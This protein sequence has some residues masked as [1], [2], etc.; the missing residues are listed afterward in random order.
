MGTGVPVRAAGWVQD[1]LLHFGAFWSTSVI[2]LVASALLSREGSG[3]E[4]V[5]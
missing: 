2:S 1:V 3:G 4:E 5:S